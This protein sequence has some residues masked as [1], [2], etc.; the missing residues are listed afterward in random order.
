M[1]NFTCPYCYSGYDKR[2]IKYVCPDCGTEAAPTGKEPIKCQSGHC[3]G[4]ATKRV[5]PVQLCERDIPRMA[6]DTPNLL[7]SIIGVSTSGKTDYIT[8]M[9]DELLNIEEL[10]LAMSHQT[11]ETRDHQKNNKRNLYEL[12]IPNQATDRGY[13]VS[14]IWYIRNLAQARRGSVPAYTFTIY[15]GS[16]EDHNEDM[17]LAQYIKSSEAFI[18]VLDPLILDRVQDFVDPAVMGNSNRN[19]ENTFNANEIVESLV[20]RIKEIKGIPATKPINMPVAVVLTKFDTIMNHP[21]LNNATVKNKNI[22]AIEG[23]KVKEEVFEQIHGEIEFW[24][25]SI[26]E[27]SFINSLDGSFAK[28]DRKGN[29]KERYY[30]F[31]GVSSYGS[32]PESPTEV[33]RIEPHRVLDPLLWLFKKKKFID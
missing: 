2:K 23:G 30:N 32:S 9:L 25:R 16:G 33:P 4:L 7:F 20:N 6:L 24:L 13:A 19:T 29:I 31:F 18:I 12:G 8:T 26:G 1:A 27:T 11:N 5:C 3:G 17:T 22:S 10:R 15:D 14:Q 28:I 21:K